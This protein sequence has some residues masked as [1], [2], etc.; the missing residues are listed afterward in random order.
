MVH[1][2]QVGDRGSQALDTR[3][4]AV[5]AAG[6]GDVNVVGAL[7]RACDLIVYFRRSLPQV[8]P[9][10]GLLLEAVLVGTLGTPDYTCGGTGGIEAGV[11]TVAFVGIS[12]L[13][14]DVGVSFWVRLGQPILASA[15]E[16][17]LRAT[18]LILTRPC[19][20]YPSV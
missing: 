2:V 18:T 13:L 17:C 7:E 19:A 16:I 15:C 14:V 9:Q 4:R 5:F 3:G 10:I 12:E 8:R 20:T 11:G 6:H 1:I